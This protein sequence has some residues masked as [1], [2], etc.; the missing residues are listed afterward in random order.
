MLDS[1]SLHGEAPRYAL[2][3]R[4]SRTARSRSPINRRSRGCSGGFGVLPFVVSFVL[5]K[6]RM[7]YVYDF[8]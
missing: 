1:L 5:R 8:G 6:D 7:A 4:A 2:R 3:S